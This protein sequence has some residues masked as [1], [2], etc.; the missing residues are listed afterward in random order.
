[1]PWIKEEN[2][3]GCGICAKKCP[4]GAISIKNRKAIMD[5]KT[6]IRCGIC[7]DVCPRNAVR[8]DSEKIPF[9]IESN[10]S[11]VNKLM[12]NFKTKDERT[13][14]IVRMKKHYNKEKVV[15]EKTLEKIEEIII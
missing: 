9:E 7:H 1:M 4:V 10:I 8:H 2:C 3:V 6:C 12:E 15:A 14:F 13:A 11:W 5:N